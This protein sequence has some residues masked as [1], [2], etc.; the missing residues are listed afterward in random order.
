MYIVKSRKIKN[1]NTGNLKKFISG[2]AM[3]NEIYLN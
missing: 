3:K 2:L 1:R